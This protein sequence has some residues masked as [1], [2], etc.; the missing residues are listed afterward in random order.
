LAEATAKV[1]GADDPSPRAISELSSHGSFSVFLAT[2]GAV[3]AT[4][5]HEAGLKPAILAG[6]VLLAVLAGWTD[7]RSRRIPNWLT[8]PALLTGLVVNSALSGWSG[9]KTSLLGAGLCLLL[10]LPFVL[11]RSLGAGDWKLAGALGAFAGPATLLDL[12]LGSVFVAGLMAVALVIY[13]G[14][15]RQTM[16]NIGHILVSLVTFR[17]PG[18]HVS[19]D[20]PDSL[21][22]PY[23]VA[24]ALTVVLYGAA[25][26]WRVV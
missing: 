11:L 26:A 24:L 9:L 15:V 4:A 1:A 7:L 14:R 23:G 22:V 25:H 13:K 17:L 20:S 18:S 21:K 3:R 19:L 16:R 12:L 6:A 10:L 2:E 5:R 8:V